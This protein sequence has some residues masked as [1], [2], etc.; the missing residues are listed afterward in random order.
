MAKVDAIIQEGVAAIK[1]GRKDDAKRVLMRAIDL[2]ERSE[3]A[4]L[5]LSACALPH[6][7]C[8]PARI[9]AET[10]RGSACRLPKRLAKPRAMRPTE[11]PSIAAPI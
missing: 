6:S 11:S 1:A 4:W 3:Q 8:P 2:D 9:S 7:P 10:I 5:W